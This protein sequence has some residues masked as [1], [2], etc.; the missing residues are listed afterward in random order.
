[1]DEELDV[2]Y[3][4]LAMTDDSMVTPSLRMV[5]STRGRRPEVS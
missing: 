2:G 3:F 1:M 4:G 5:L